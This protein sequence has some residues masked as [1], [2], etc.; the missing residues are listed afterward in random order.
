MKMGE[1]LDNLDIVLG[2][3]YHLKFDYL[4]EESDEN[5]TR[6]IFGGCEA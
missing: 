1:V 3:N 6:V 2:E 5:D 4:L